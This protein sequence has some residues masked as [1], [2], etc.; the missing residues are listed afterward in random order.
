LSTRAVGCRPA[1]AERHARVNHKSDVQRAQ[2]LLAEKPEVTSSDEEGVNGH[3]GTRSAGSDDAEDG[4]SYCWVSRAALKGRARPITAL[5][6]WPSLTSC[7]SSEGCV[8]AYAAWLRAD[9]ATEAYVPEWLTADIVC[10]HDQLV[11]DQTLRQQ[12][13]S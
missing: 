8:C 10:P 4:S 9:G 13:P 3:S 1:D 5:C 12:V 2:R 11:P 6:A 7:T